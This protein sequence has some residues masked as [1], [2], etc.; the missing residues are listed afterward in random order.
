M[1]I[2]LTFKRYVLLITFRVGS[3]FTASKQLHR[4]TF[5]NKRKWRSS[6]MW[7]A[8][9]HRVFTI[10]TVYCVKAK[11][12]F[13][14]KVESSSHK[15]SY[16]KSAVTTLRYRKIDFKI[17]LKVPNWNICVWTTSKK[18]WLPNGLGSDNTCS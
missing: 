5:P 15:V 12:C 14:W 13:S 4:I 1:F 16:N 17:V 8:L 6:D 9:L 11:K 18:W 2:S 7:L 10:M 3:T